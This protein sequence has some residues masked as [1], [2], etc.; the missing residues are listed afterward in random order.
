MVDPAESHQQQVAAL[1]TDHRGWLQTWLS[2]KLGDSFAAADL[3]QDT[4][5]RVLR[6]G[7]AGNVQSPRAYLTVIAGGLVKDHWR[8]H[9]LEQAWLE[10]LAARPQALAPS[11]EE[12]ALVLETLGQIARLLDGLPTLTREAFLLSQLDGLTY[13]QIAQHQG[14]TVNRV[15]KAMIVAVKHCYQALYA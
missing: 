8:R 2:R 13:P 15:Q 3:T 4:F 5:L 9:A 7:M 12:R 6:R 11:P 1:Y 10:E 14:I